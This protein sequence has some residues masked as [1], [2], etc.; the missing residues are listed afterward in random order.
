MQNPDGTVRDIAP[1]AGV[2]WLEGTRAALFADLDND[3][4]QDL[5][6]VFGSK[7]V[8][9]ANDGRGHFQLRTI[10]DT[11]SSLFS[12]NAVDYDNDSDLDLFI[13]GYTLSS[14]VNLDDVFANPM[15]FHDANNGAPNVM[16]RGNAW[17]MLSR[18][19]S[20]T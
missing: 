3:G 7:V 11:V 6:A 5:V 2:N 12:I 16:L 4:D 8:I 13:C 9:Q 14:G 19:K 18:A 20:L 17:T 15:P 10:V 1:E